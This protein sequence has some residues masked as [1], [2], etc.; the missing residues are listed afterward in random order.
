MNKIKT[1]T[2][3]YEYQNRTTDKNEYIAEEFE[4]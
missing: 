3:F 1:K 4:V 2:N